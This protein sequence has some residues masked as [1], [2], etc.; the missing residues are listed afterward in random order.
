MLELA[1]RNLDKMSIRLWDDEAKEAQFVE[2]TRDDITGNGRI[3][4]RAARHFAEQAEIVQ[5][6]TQFYNSAVGSDPSIRAHFSSI[7]IAKM[8]EQLLDIEEYKLVQENVRITENA[9]AKQLANV[10]EEN[11]LAANAQPSGVIPGDFV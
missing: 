8:F 4:P 9:Q 2:L 1:R 10:N 3:Y 6:L 11:T 7:G 5:N